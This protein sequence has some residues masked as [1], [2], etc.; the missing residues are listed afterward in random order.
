MWC[1]YMQKFRFSLYKWGPP[2]DQNWTIACMYTRISHNIQSP[3]IQAGGIPKPLL[4]G[5]RIGNPE[6]IEVIT[7]YAGKH[8]SP[9]QLHNHFIYY[10]N[11]WARTNIST[12]LRPNSVRRLSSR[13]IESLLKS[14]PEFPSYKRRGTSLPAIIRAQNIKLKGA[15][16]IPFIAHIMPP[17][18]INIDH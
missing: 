14:S 6:H 16:L 15:K 10:L 4:D 18:E 17:I 9:E 5:V 7:S 11:M 3:D 1:T 12:V 2:T 13:S 8:K